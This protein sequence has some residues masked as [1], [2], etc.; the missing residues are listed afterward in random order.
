MPSRTGAS[1][2]ADVVV[3]GVVVAEGEGDR[4]AA[5]R[6]AHGEP[7]H[8]GGEVA[9]VCVEGGL[10]DAGRCAEPECVGGSRAGV[11]GGRDGDAVGG[12]AGEGDGVGPGVG[13]VGGVGEG[14]EHEGATVAAR[15]GVALDDGE[16]S[17][18]P[19]SASRRKGASKVTPE[20]ASAR[21]ISRRG[22]H[23]PS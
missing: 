7:E 12:I 23:A 22:D 16:T 20:P 17:A 21:V 6:L 10:P 11:G 4:A 8:V 19:P 3:A 5:G 18:S 14:G 15:A 1:G 2:V 9:G 13:V